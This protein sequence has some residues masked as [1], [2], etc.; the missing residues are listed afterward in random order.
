MNNQFLTRII[1][2]KRQE[3][4]Q[5]AATLPLR[6]LQ[7][8]LLSQTFP[9]RS[10]RQKLENDPRFH[11]ICEIK[12]AS[13]SRGIIQ[14]NCHPAERAQAYVAGGASAISV[15]TD[16]RFF[17]GEL[18]DL[19]SVRRQVPIPVLRKDFILD[20]YQVYESRVAGA[21]LILLIAAILPARTVDR[22]SALAR[23]LGMEVLLELH[24]PEEISRIPAQTDHIILGINNRDLN[25]FQVD[26]NHAFR[27]KPLLPA[28]MPVI[29]ESG[30]S[31]PDVC[32]RLRQAGFQGA[33]IGEA[34][35]REPHPGPLLQQFQQEVNDVHK[36]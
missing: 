20:E 15:L 10:L 11:F 14:P 18:Y 4:Q 16:A 9:V 29:S 33:L 5:R 3:V 8:M 25:S 35:M 28:D 19:S 31:N 12:K 17:R 6:E 36:T 22:L 23:D 27:V 1:E 13:P 2:H 26:V 30:I 34:L 7:R 21:D 32:R 24:H